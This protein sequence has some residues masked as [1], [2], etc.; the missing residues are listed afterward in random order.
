MKP[1]VP[2]E[3]PL[4]YSHDPLQ[5]V[6][7]QT[8]SAQLP[9]MHSVPAVHACPIFF[10]QAPLASQVLAPVQ[11]SGSSAFV[12]ATQVPPGPVHDWHVPHEAKLQQWPS[13]QDLPLH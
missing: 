12:T 3:L 2:G 9:P 4:Q 5:A 1:Q 11:L 13:T 7:Q 6:L 8:L 10:L